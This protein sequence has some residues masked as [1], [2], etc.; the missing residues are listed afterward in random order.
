MMDDNSFP[1]TWVETIDDDS[2]HGAVRCLWQ[3]NR[4]QGYFVAP[5]LTRDIEP[6]FIVG[7]SVRDDSLAE[8][9]SRQRT[10]R[11][12]KECLTRATCICDYS[13]RF[14]LAENWDHDE[15]E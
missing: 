5:D 11:R 9:L 13:R 3:C 12:V 2:F 1:A 6:V 7:I 15:S 10:R 14:V 4:C 8:R